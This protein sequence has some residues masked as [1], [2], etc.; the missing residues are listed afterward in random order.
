VAH[1]R[2]LR[3]G[4]HT[5]GGTLQYGR[6]WSRRRRRYSPVHSHL[7]GEGDKQVR[8]VD[9]QLAGGGADLGHRNTDE[10]GPVAVVQ[11]DVV[12]A[13]EPVR[14]VVFLQDGDT[15]PKVRQGRA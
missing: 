12:G 13:Q 4:P 9:G 14:Q 3:Y 11:E 7:G 10:P 2:S 1:W 15:V 8:Y 6:T 5:G